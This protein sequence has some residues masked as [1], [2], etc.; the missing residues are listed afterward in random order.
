[1]S[2]TKRRA[3]SAYFGSCSSSSSYSFSVDPQPPALVTIA[4]NPPSTKASIFM[5]RHF[6]PVRLKHANR[7][8][9]EPGETDVGNTS[10]EKP[11]PILPVSLRGEYA[12][13][14]AIEKWLLNLWS[15]R[16]EL[17]EPAGH[18]NAQCLIE[19]QCGTRHP[20]I[21]TVGEE[22]LEDQFSQ[23]ARRKGTADTLF[24]LG[25]PSFH[26]AAVFDPGWARRFTSAAG[27]AQFDM[28]DVRLGDGGAVGDLHHLVNSAARGIHLYVKLAISRA[29]VEA[30][31]AVDALIQI[32]YGGSQIRSAHTSVPDLAVLPGRAL[33]L[34]FP[35]SQGRH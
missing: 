12:T 33:P 17:T 32:A 16:L 14:V 13:H 31:S 2:A 5:N 10:G 6:A 34:L 29:G 35:S 21:C 22:V 26:Q 15:E 28:L 1:M 18:A 20:Q 4:S 25:S 19:S 30:Q 11:D 27:K 23:H 8:F 7:G 3:R 9:I 24:D